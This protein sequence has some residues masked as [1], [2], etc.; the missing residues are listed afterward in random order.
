MKAVMRQPLAAR[1]SLSAWMPSGVARVYLRC[2]WNRC[3]QARSSSTLTSVPS[4]PEG[5]H[6]GP[7]VREAGDF[8]VQVAAADGPFLLLGGEERAGCGQSGGGEGQAGGLYKVT[9]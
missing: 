2:G 5:L 3:A 1:S 6:A 9:A 8:E 4:A 7:T